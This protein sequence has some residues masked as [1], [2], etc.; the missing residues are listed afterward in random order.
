MNAVSGYCECAISRLKMR[1]VSFFVQI[2]A[3]AA[4]LDS[5][6]EMRFLQMLRYSNSG[7]GCYRC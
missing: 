6:E 2:L 3:I 7:S 4:Q 1:H 5:V